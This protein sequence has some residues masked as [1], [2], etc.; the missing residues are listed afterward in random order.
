MHDAMSL[1]DIVWIRTCCFT[2]VKQQ[3]LIPAMA[4]NVTIKH[5]RLVRVKNIEDMH[6]KYYYCNYLLL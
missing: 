6:A 2:A 5:C 1:I 4:I 3:V